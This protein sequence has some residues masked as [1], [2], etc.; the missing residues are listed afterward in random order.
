[1]GVFSEHSAV[2][3]CCENVFVIFLCRR[4]QMSEWRTPTT[5]IA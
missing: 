5:V 2:L 1:V 3:T 4:K